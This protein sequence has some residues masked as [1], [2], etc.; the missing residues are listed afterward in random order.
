ML[1]CSSVYIIR[2]Y[3]FTSNQGNIVA[4]FLFCLSP[5]SCVYEQ[6]E[7]CCVIHSPLGFVF[8]CLLSLLTS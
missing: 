5:V 4:C 8:V 6:Q 3:V 2:M 7:H 1:K